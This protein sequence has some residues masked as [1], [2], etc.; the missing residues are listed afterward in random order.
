MKKLG[1]IALVAIL[2]A[3]GSMLPIATPRGEAVERLAEAA[4]GLSDEAK[5]FAKNADQLLA[6]VQERDEQFTKNLFV[7]SAVTIALTSAWIGGNL[8][9]AKIK[10]KREQEKQVKKAA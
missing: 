5:T 2:F 3:S 7:L 10:T 6:N 9:Y 1:Y 8:A 4:E